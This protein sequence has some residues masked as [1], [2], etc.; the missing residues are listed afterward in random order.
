MGWFTTQPGCFL[1]IFNSFFK[2]NVFF[3][4]EIIFFDEFFDSD[5]VDFLRVLVV[6]HSL[7]AQD[8]EVMLS[9]AMSFVSYVLQQLAC[10]RMSR[11]LHRL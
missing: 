7:V 3:S 8:V 9:E 4:R 1:Y 11:Q 2:P 10:R 5:L 6:Q